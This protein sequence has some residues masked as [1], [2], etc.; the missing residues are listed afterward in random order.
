MDVAA[1]RLEIAP[2]LP[3]DEAARRLE[4]APDL[5]SDEAARRLEIA[6]RL[7]SDEAAISFFYSS[8]FGVK[9]NP[10][11]ALTVIIKK[12]GYP[13]P[14]KNPVWHPFCTQS[15]VPCLTASPRT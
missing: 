15:L 10:Y 13:P 4:I 12:Q 7:P 8:T 2:G 6:P 9:H 3:C 11:T 1:R 14:K 5:P